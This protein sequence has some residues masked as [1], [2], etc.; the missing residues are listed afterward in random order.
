[1]AHADRQSGY[2]LLPVVLAITLVAA[3]AFLMNHENAL[4]LK[5]LN[6]N[7]EAA[8]ADYIAQAGMAHA[9]WGVQNSGCVGDMTM[10]TVPLGQGSYSATVDAG[11]PTTTSYSLTPDRDTWIKEASPDENNAG[12]SLLSVKIKPGDSFRALYHYHLSSIPS[13]KKVV[14]STAWFYLNQNDNQGAV[15]LHPITTGW[16]PALI[17]R[18][19]WYVCMLMVPRCMWVQSPMNRQPKQRICGLGIPWM[20]STGTVRSTISVFIAGC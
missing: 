14:T 4:N 18:L 2:I 7:F 8:Q 19:M 13:N 9:T 3:I 11:G 12:V 15:T 16:L 10:T 6:N 17:M 20:A 5:T 1:M